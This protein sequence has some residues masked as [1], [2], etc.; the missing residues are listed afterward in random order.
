MV[1]P[2]TMMENLPTQLAFELS[3]HHGPVRAV[4]FNSYV[5]PQLEASLLLKVKY[6][7]HL[8]LTIMLR[9]CN[10]IL[11]SYYLLLLVQLINY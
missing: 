9:I 6:E 2:T 8:M 7:I 10:V 3:T 5:L 11:E 4:R 1:R